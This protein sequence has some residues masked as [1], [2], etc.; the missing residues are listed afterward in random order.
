MPD[1]PGGFT[2]MAD[3]FAT[4]NATS[5]ASSIGADASPADVLD[6]QL[7]YLQSR[8]DGI[9]FNFL[10]YESEQLVFIFFFFRF[11]S[12]EHHTHGTS[13]TISLSFVHDVQQ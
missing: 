10:K 2:V 3:T 11:F 4:L 5:L 7:D 12:S 9:L 6:A 8:K 13:T 1:A